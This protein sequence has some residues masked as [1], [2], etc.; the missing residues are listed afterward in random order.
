MPIADPDHQAPASMW[1]LERR[2]PW[3]LLAYAAAA[4]ATCA[5][6]ALYPWGLAQ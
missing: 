2:S 4:V 6:S 3:A 5:L 1:D